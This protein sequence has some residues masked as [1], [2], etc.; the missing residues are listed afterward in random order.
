MG[1]EMRGRKDGSRNERERGWE[2][3]MKEQKQ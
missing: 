2:K 1:E 3:A